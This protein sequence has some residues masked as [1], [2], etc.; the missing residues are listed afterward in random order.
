[1]NS[2]R[3]RLLRIIPKDTIGIE[4]GVWM[5][6]FTGQLLHYVKPSRLHLVDPWIYQNGFAKY[7]PSDGQ[8]HLD[9]MYGDVAKSYGH[10]HNVIIHREKSE[11]IVSVFPDE[12][13]DW[14]YIDGDHSEPGV[15]QDLSNYWMTTTNPPSSPSPPTAKSLP[16]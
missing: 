11:E 8:K 16:N 1:M 10:L 7:F 9:I 6:E 13:F 5:G 4:I 2:R 15:Y 14:L 12:Y 3:K